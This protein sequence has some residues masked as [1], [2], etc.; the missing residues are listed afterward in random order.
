MGEV[1]HYLGSSDDGGTIR[2]DDGDVVH[3]RLHPEPL[4]WGTRQW[5][6]PDVPVLPY[7]LEEQL[8]GSK[9]NCTLTPPI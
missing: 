7:G 2:A 5:V 3:V 4:F 1:L 8:K 6:A 9:G